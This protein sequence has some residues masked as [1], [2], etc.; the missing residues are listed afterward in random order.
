MRSIK[1]KLKKKKMEL[2]Y[3]FQRTFIL[4]KNLYFWW[5]ITQ[6]KGITSLG[7]LTLSVDRF[8]ESD[9]MYLMYG[10]RRLYKILK[11]VSESP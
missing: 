5:S 7:H 8:N 11:T 2:Y 4:Q 10:Y 3:L 9:L 6:M 1:Q